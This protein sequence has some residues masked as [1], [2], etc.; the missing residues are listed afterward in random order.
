MTKNETIHVRVNSNVKNS[1]E[2]ALDM[3]GISV[4]EAINM[5]LCQVSL[6]GGI[7]FD[8]KLPAPEHVI[9]RSEDELIAKLDDSQ[10]DI[11]QGRTSPASEVYS[12][13]EAKY[14]F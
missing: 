6:V 10:K 5:F 4:S 1:A 3:L 11:E 2:S 7:P 9:V 14:G 8:V 13:L 12:R